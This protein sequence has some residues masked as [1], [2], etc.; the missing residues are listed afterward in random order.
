M[1]AITAAAGGGN[2][3][4]GGTWTGGVAPTA[5]DD[6]ILASTS[7]NV[8]IDTNSAVA[9]SLDCTGYTGTLTGT[10]GVTLKLGTSTPGAGNI[11]LKFVAGMTFVVPS[12]SSAIQFVSTSATQQTVT[13][14]G[15]LMCVVSFNGAGSSYLLSDVFS[16]VSGAYGFSIFNGTVNTNNLNHTFGSGSWTGGTV[17]LG[18]SNITM[19]G[20][21]IT[22]ILDIGVSM[23]FTAN[24][25]TLTFTAN[26]ITGIKVR[27]SL[28]GAAVVF[29]TGALS[30]NIDSTV[31]LGNVT[32]TGATLKAASLAFISNV[33]ITGTL[34]VSGSSLVNRPLLQSNAIG[35]ART[36]TT[37]AFS[38][39]GVDF[40][41]ITAAGAGGTWTGTSMGNCLGN[42]NIT[43]DAS[44]TQIRTGVGG[45]WS[46]SGNWTSRVPLPQ[47]TVV[48]AGAASGTI[49]ADMPRWGADVNFTGFAGTCTVPI[50]VA[51]YGSVTMAAGM[52]WS[53]T[54][55]NFIFS[56]R[57][58]HTLTTANKPFAFV[59]GF[60]GGGTYT[61]Q[62]NWTSN[63]GAFTLY[64]GTFDA[65]NFN[66]SFGFGFTVVAGE[67][68]RTLNMGTGTW[69]CGAGAGWV[70]AG[71][72]TT[73][74][75]ST[76]TITFTATASARTFAG[77]GFTYNILSYTVAGSTGSLTITGANTFNTINFSDSTNVRSLLF[78]AGT[79]T[80]VTNWNVNGT[81]GKLMT[82]D[83]VTA[84]THT[85]SK[86]S[87]SVSAD[88]L[89]IGHSSAS[90]GALWYAGAN[91]VDNGGNTGWNFTVPQIFSGTVALAGSGSLSTVVAPSLIAPAAL[92]GA[93]SLT[94]TGTPMGVDG[95]SGTG[96]L[97]FSGATAAIPV[98]GPLAGSGSLVVTGRPSIAGA[99]AVLGG[100]GL[101][102]TTVAYPWLTGKGTLTLVPGPLS[103]V[104]TVAVHGAGT[105]TTPGAKGTWTAVSV[106]SLSG[107]GTMVPAGR[108]IVPFIP[109]SWPAYT[110]ET[111]RYVVQD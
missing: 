35:T 105:L 65:N 110:L 33:T 83:S 57:G 47:D 5:S 23:T 66:V 85:L 77:G 29:G 72:N 101:L 36:V 79:L 37:A 60:R 19:S 3:T 104:L 15:K 44:T 30:G 58:N 92:S 41:D 16:S 40:Q 20:G 86:V 91:S 28:N 94:T 49:T 31:S 68:T 107:S 84:A 42:S 103:F 90:G 87:G 48:I 100:S 1:A 27:A 46:T 52:T 80:S 45:N 73:I 88:Y 54:V 75:A 109:R 6:A 70:A 9:R 50:A 59:V 34:S 93:G 96:S 7:G 98:A 22:N 26:G 62:D 21:S 25:G 24:T 95:L 12:N 17:T 71:P 89:S 56:G 78:T 13:T 74:N 55:A 63:S 64:S 11:A 38:F 53:Q 69:T 81:A 8:T 14:G 18:S 106:A 99:V 67:L 76:S 4:A 61:L 82:V 43:F 97:S 2:W 39:T 10:T 32:F 108:W 102:R 111:L 51:L